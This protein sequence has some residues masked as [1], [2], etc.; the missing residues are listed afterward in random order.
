MIRR[1]T[2]TAHLS[3]SEAVP[4]VARA[5]NQL[6]QSSHPALRRL[7]YEIAGRQLVLNGQ[8]PSYYLKQLAQSAGVA[9][10]LVVVNRVRV[11]S[12]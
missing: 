3:Q 12:S 9:N 7:T 2:Y 5:L 8:V 4:D 10:G 6:K 11:I 1:E